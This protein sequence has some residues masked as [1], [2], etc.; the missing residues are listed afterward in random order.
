[1][2]SQMGL[3][4]GFH[5][6]AVVLFEVCDDEVRLQSEDG[7]DVSRFGPADAGNPT[8]GLGWAD[9]EFR[10][11]DDVHRQVVQEFGPTGHQRNHAHGAKVVR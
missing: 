11:P 8:E 7:F 1:M 3:L 2:A 9:A 6:F 4:K 5:L 10:L